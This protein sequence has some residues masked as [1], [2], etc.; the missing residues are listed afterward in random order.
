MT[1]D[2]AT[3]GR[4]GVEAVEQAGADLER[5]R[6]RLVEVA[7]ALVWRRA[8]RH[9]WRGP[10]ADEASRRYAEVTAHV[11]ALAARLGASAQALSA[12][13]PSLRSARDLV[14]RA[15]DRCVQVGGRLTDTGR[16]LP[17]PPTPSAVDPVVAAHRARLDAVVTAEVDELVR[18]ALDVA[19][20]ADRALG[21]ALVSAATGRS[22]AAWLTTA[23]TP[24]P[25]PPVGAVTGAQDAFR[26]AAWWRSLTWSQREDAIRRH[27]DWVGPR[28]GVPA[29]ARH[30]AN[31]VLLA[32]LE[33]DQRARL[34]AAAWWDVDGRQEAQEALDDLLAVRAVLGR[35]VGG[36]RR[37]LLLVQAPY[38]RVRAVL[39]VGDVDGDPHVA[40]LVGG[41]STSVRGDALRLD[42]TAVR[43]R[44]QAG[45]GNGA[46]AVVTWI[47][48]DAPRW[49][50]LDDTRGTVLSPVR[51]RESADELAAFS[52]GVTAARDD[53]VHQTVLGHSYGSVV[54]G[55]ALLQ[56]HTLDDAVVFGSPGVPFTDVAQ[57]GLRPG[58]LNV[59]AATRAGVATPMTAV[60]GTDPTDVAGI[61]WLSAAAL[62]T[63]VGS[64]NGRPV[65]YTASTGHSQYLSPGTTSERNLAAVA[66]GRRDRVVVAGRRERRR[67]PR[68]SDANPFQPQPRDLP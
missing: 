61:A 66:S 7:A 64:T 18:R 17:P 63:T 15:D 10:A 38:G 57:T 51:A 54:T 12:A 65:T 23:P 45:T 20:S 35:A 46:L 37:R 48:Y 53:P 27:P 24:A 28:D 8:A 40:T 44:S 49:R 5:Q 42:D 32:R 43:L 56:P 68:W 50:D 59:L 2:A 22:L 36:E 39:A 41:L 55:T 19:A 34:A 47:G 67:H 16:Y 30:E 29:W 26:A 14:R 58:G 60:L 3:V 33:A 4:L 1:W 6:A 13:V 62:K 21:A 9:S 11:T 52:A 31:L 25:P